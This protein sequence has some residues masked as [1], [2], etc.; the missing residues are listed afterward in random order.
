[1]PIAQSQAALEIFRKVVAGYDPFYLAG[2]QQAVSVSGSLILGLALAEGKATAA[3]VFSAAELESLFQ[4]EK[5][6]EDPVTSARHASVKSDL[7]D[8]RQWFEGLKNAA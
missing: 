6:G 3:E 7:D 4:M 1:M 8:C 5:W 2:L